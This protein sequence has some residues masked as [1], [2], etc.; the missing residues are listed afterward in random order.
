MATAAS[1]SAQDVDEPS[2][3]DYETFL[4]PDFRPTS[5]A[6]TL[7]VATNNPNDSPLD[8]STPLSRVLF[9]AQEVDSHID[10]L[11]TRSA[12][13][14][15]RYTQQ[16]TSA[17]GRIVSEL[18]AQIKS[19]ND[20]Y[21][22]LEREV[23][24]KHAE[25]DEVRQV[26]LRL[27]ETL[28]LGQAVARCLQL[29][30]QLEIQHSELASTGKD[31]YSALVRCSHTI[32]S[33]REILESRAPGEEGHGLQRVDAIRTLQDQVVNPME[34]S[35]RE[36]AERIVR[37]FAIPANMT[38]AQGEEARAKMVWAI[39]TLYLL[40]PTLA[41]KPDKWTPRLLLQ[42]LETYIRSALQISIT[43][44][45]RSLGQL[46]TLE[47][48]LGDVTAK[49]QNIVS[50]ELIL[51]STKPP[52]H[53]LFPGA[54][55][56]H[57]KVPSLLQPLLAHLETGSL[58]SYF[59][60]TMASS[61][62]ARV[63]D[64]VSRGGVVARTLRTNKGS[65]GDA[66]RL[67]VARGSLPPSAMVDGKTKPK[68][69][70]WDRESAVM[71]GSVVNNLGSCHIRLLAVPQAATMAPNQGLVHLKEYDVKDSNVELIGTDI[72]H[73]VKYNSA[74]TE[75][76]WH[77]GGVGEEAGLYI[78]RI[79][80]FQVV[81]WPRNKY[82]T[83]Y[84]GDSFIVLHS[85]KVGEREGQEH[86]VH[87]IFFW[88]G[89]HTSKDE[90]GVA[91]YKTVELDEFLRGSAVQHREVQQAPSDDFLALF[92]RMSI[93]SGGVASGFRHV[94][95]ETP[96]DITTLLRV[97]KNP[98]AN[99]VVVYEVEPSWRSLDNADVFV[100]DKGD[101]VW[102]WQGKDC[103]PMEKAKAAQVVHD[104]ILAKHAEVEVLAQAESRSRRVV[105]L[106]GGDADTPFD[107][108][109][110]RPVASGTHI[111]DGD[112]SSRPQRLFRFSDESGRLEF[113]LVRD[114][115][116]ISHRDLDGSDVFLL[117]DAGRAIWV[118]EGRGASRAEKAK[119]L[120]VAQAYARHIQGEDEQAYLTPIAKVV[121]GNE[122]RAF[123]KAIEV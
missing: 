117:D 37:D 115:G 61:L 27:W 10:Q 81:P 33:L 40:S 121:E 8:L 22:Q 85:F 18:D 14:L 67:A 23:V 78:W 106:L 35:V 64:I 26:A 44:L 53:P 65:V 52:P 98:G 51:E 69:G 54:A 94:E 112:A 34:R 120:H 58:P 49:C 7:V 9:D 19:L 12:V 107:F 11:T 31:D 83:F 73:R 104:M 88:L 97:F 74:V 109:Q 4:A 75:P 70:N 36:T 13:P 28:R 113:S 62:A 5:F 76:A 39:N 96:Q 118:W 6:N 63:Q 77:E 47:K 110:P 32:L 25:A 116:P 103:S 68:Q 87:D 41:V 114:G 1:N 48:A 99:G 101:K 60:R 111:H 15:L 91:A 100:L 43:S 55:S 108:H 86:L 29:G 66:I 123:L 50:L 42:N 82:G 38:F 46:P 59:W 122:S 90:A 80:D 30:R 72:D 93:R 95:E 71:V 79:E 56:P 21:R 17:S 57:Q 119:W 45:A 84:D 2:Y 105:D 3:V 102:V 89:A 24:D 92:P 16:Q 20:S